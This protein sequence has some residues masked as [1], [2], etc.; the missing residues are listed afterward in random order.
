MLGTDNY[1]VLKYLSQHWIIMFRVSTVKKTFFT[2]SEWL[3][4]LYR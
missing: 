3:L 4:M 2:D 1:L